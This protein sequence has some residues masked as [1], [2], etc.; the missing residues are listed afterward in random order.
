MS[1]TRRLG[2]LYAAES[3]QNNYRYLVNADFKAY[4]FESLRDTLLNYIQTNY[5]ED[6]NDFI[7]SSEYVALVDL[8]AFLGQ[9]LAFRSDLNLRETFLE[10]AEVRGNVL[11]IAR[12]LGYKPFRSNAATG[13]LR[14]T[15]ISTTQQVY[16]NK[17]QN[18]AGQTI[19]WADP[20]NP[21]FN[22]QW[23]TIMNEVLTSGNP[24]GR[25]I[26]SIVDNGTVRQIYQVNQ[27]ENRTMVEAFNLTSRSTS[28]YSCEIVP[29]I[30]DVD[31][32][33]PIENDPDP[34]GYLT[35]LFNND[36]SGYTNATNGW[37]F[38]FKQGVLKYE[39]YV[40]NTS[41]ENRVID[42]QNNSI[43]ESDVWVQS[44]DGD[45]FI[46]E[47]WTKVPSVV[48]Q[49]IAFSAI[50]KDVRAL[51]ETIPQANDQVS[52]KFGDGT[53]ST[54]PT[55]N[56]RVWFRQ[57]ETT[58]VTFTPQDVAGLQINMRY[59]D[60]N[61]VEQDLTVTLELINSTSN[62]PSETLAQIKSRAS[63]TAAS[64]ERMITASDYNTYPE[65]KVGGVSKIKSIN[66]TYAGQSVY[67]DPQDPT[68]TYR[69]VITFAQDGYIYRK[70]A[71][72]Q[73]TISDLNSTTDTIKWIENNLLNRSLHQF[74]YTRSTQFV[75][76]RGTELTTQLNWHKIDYSSG[77]THGYFYLSNDIEKRPVRVGKGSVLLPH[78]TIKKDSLLNF[79][80][81]GW[82]KIIDVYREGFG[83]G[84]SAGANTGLR[85]NGQGAVFLD[86]IIPS[87]GV[88]K[89]LPNLRT[90]FKVSEVTAISNEINARRQFG[91]RYD[92]IKDIWHVI[93]VD[94]LNVN[95]AFDVTFAGDGTNA[96]KD[97]SW[98]INVNH[99][100]NSW[101]SQL[102]QDNTI[103]GSVKELSFHNQRF[104]IA[105]D[106]STQRI[107]KDTVKFLTS[108]QNITKEYEL[109]VFD[110]FRI[111]DGRYDPTRLQVV[112]PGL[113]DTLV[114]KDP[115]IFNY[116]INDSHINLYKEEFSDSPGQFTVK[117]TT[118]L[119]EAGDYNNTIGRQNLK[120]QFNHV[121][122]RDNRVD[123]T[124]TNIIDMFILT[125]QYDSDARSWLSSGS[126]TQT[127]PFPL[128]S[129]E[130]EK[131]MSTIIPYKSVSDTIVFHPVRY[132]VL[133]GK[134]ASD[135]R[136]QATIRITKSDGTRVSDAEISSRVITTI[137]NYFN[138]TNWDFGET[139]Y[140]TDMA[141]WVH[142]Q[143]GGSISSIALIPKQNGLTSNDLFQIR[144]DDD[145]MFISSATVADVEI[146]TGLVS[147]TVATTNF[148]IL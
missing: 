40:L 123:A 68:G 57:S 62:S 60:S 4:D 113:L 148:S 87:T 114:P 24:I 71:T 41:L 22:E 45:G 37:F 129:Y 61:Q 106:Q 118:N 112:L 69:P 12:Q 125:D 59:V 83:I 88:E 81:G 139:F 137:N 73:D 9:N 67:V 90:I 21:N 72:S 20:L 58:P 13:F 131:M 134:G 2:Q 110:Y 30:I 33:L 101:A 49:N 17:G 52:I 132:K 79:G 146:I 65:G 28:T 43:N 1:Q 95:S 78:R 10:T 66:R 86:G 35:M 119:N 103:F 39:D 26:S 64:Q 63:R 50:N 140:F 130:L 97:A 133:F 127:K 16:D 142:K 89:W 19:V 102:R 122:L 15:A 77:T 92:H 14:L 120:V 74:Y 18:L 11:N 141:A 85:A 108:N 70:D 121:P 80:S 6:F 47:T 34:Y 91:L 76:I 51:Y 136:N 138:M 23:S 105:L 104:G 75:P 117:P 3:W 126:N 54:I 144:C 147:P 48:G 115:E 32:Q 94:N 84:D 7:N 109:D 38:M 27:P 55:G 124:T 96:R 93:K 99:S 111:G 46:L 145:E 25:P 42:L 36:G 98:L 5:P 44:I 128:T 135:L 143:L 53:F 29:L 56:I 107:I 82:A 116:I 100:F 8:I 31:S